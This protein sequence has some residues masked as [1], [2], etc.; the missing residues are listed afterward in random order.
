MLWTLSDQAWKNE[1]HDEVATI[2]RSRTIGFFQRDE[3]AHR[4]GRLTV[5]S[6]SSAVGTRRISGGADSSN[7]QPTRHDAA[8][9]AQ[10]SASER[11]D[12]V[13]PE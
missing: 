3:F 12:S 13:S 2:E 4:R 11:A 1:Y 9:I 8:L 5:V 10:E 7:A 6:Q